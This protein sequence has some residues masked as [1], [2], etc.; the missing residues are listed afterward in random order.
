METGRKKASRWLVRMRKRK[1]VKAVC[2]VQ[3][4]ETGRPEVC[5]G[6]RPREG[7]ELHQVHVTDAELLLG[8]R[9]E[10]GVTL[11]KARPDGL[12][13]IGGRECAVE[14]DN[15]RMSRKQMR[16]KW[17]TYDG[18]DVFILVITHAE[19][20]MHRLRKDAAGVADKALFTTFDRLR[21]G[22]PWVDHAGEAVR[23]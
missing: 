1:K 16:A 17:Q 19:E 3:R 11:G 15:S 22:G 4:R 23:L 12:A 5:Y 9:I 21:A 20:R 13:R 14:V 18:Q 7:E 2:M 10:T 6:R 8:H